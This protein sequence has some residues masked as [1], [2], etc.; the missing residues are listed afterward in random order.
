MS[1]NVNGPKRKR[2]RKAK[3]AIQ[4][5][6]GPIPQSPYAASSAAMSGKFHTPVTDVQ[7]G[8]V[9]FSG[10]APHVNDTNQAPTDGGTI[11]VQH[12]SF[13]NAWSLGPVQEKIDASTSTSGE[14]F[15]ERSASEQA[16]AVEDEIQLVATS[17]APNLKLET[18]LVPSTLRSNGAPH[19]QDF[20]ALVSPP[21]SSH[22]DAETSPSSSK[23]QQTP[24][25]STSRRSSEQPKRPQRYT[26]ESG[27]ARRASSSTQGALASGKSASPRISLPPTLGEVSNKAKR[28]KARASSGEASA[29]GESLKLIRELAAQDLGLRKRGRA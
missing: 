29:D 14:P 16:D 25:N 5:M 19:N 13:T 27:I 26:P 11:K 2:P 8:Q 17:P 28:G 4:T 12:H 7:G 21:D 6:N 3:D 1:G 15:P 23:A 10:K 18:D 24:S 22:T 9:L 20:S